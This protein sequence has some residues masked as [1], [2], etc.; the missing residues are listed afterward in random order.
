MEKSKPAT[1]KVHEAAYTFERPVLF[2]NGEGK[3]TSSFIDLSRRF[4]TCL[5]T[6]SDA[7][8]L[9]LVKSLLDK[10]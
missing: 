3:N 4:T 9:R 7:C 6:Y 2:D 8:N 5:C 1:D 10:R